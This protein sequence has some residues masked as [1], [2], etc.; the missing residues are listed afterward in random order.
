MSVMWIDFIVIMIVN[1][2]ITWKPSFKI[3]LIKIKLT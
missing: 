1:I 2:S 3:N